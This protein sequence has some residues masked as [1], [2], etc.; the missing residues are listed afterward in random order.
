VDPR[1][2]AL[3]DEQGAVDPAGARELHVGEQQEELVCAL[4]RRE[5]RFSRRVAQPL[6]QQ[7]QKAVAD[8]KTVRRAALADLA[9][10]SGLK[11]A[12]AAAYVTAT[13][14]KLDDASPLL[15]GRDGLDAIR[16]AVLQVQQG[17]LALEVGE[18]Q[19]EDVA[20]LLRDAGFTEI[21][22]RRDL[23]AIERVVVGER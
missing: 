14:P 16:A 9:S 6:R 8:L 4:T 7:L 19:A 13:E 3:D 1:R 2:D 11:G 22:A 18:G 12:E 10:A 15:A 23:A 5:V 21:R 20:E 17:T